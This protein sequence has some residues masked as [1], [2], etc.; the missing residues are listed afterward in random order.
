MRILTLILFVFVVLTAAT[1]AGADGSSYWVPSSPLQMRIVA[2]QGTTF[3]VE[4]TN[5]SDGAA[6]FDAAGLYFIPDSS[7]EDPQR[8]GVVT[9]EGLSV[10]AHSAVRLELTSYCLDH[11]RNGPTDKVGYHLASSRM[12]AGLLT[13]LSSAARSAAPGQIQVAVWAIRDATPVTLL[14]ES[15]PATGRAHSL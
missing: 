8:L 10:A 7:R 13:A 4:V 9:G 12:P 6:A 1:P 11:H 2:R 15:L 5:P 14:G 3:S